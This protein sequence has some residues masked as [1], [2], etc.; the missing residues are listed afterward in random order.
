MLS[1]ITIAS[2]FGDFLHWVGAAF[3]GHGYLIMAVLIAGESAGLPLPGETSLLA[4]AVAAERGHLDIYLVILIAAGAAIVGDNIGY[5]FGRRVGRGLLERHAHLLRISERKI[6]VLEYSFAQHGA[7][8][9]FFGRWVT[10]LRST[11]GPLAG[12]SHMPWPRF[13]LFN[14]LGGLSWAATMGTLGYVFSASVS[15]IKSTFGIVGAV[16]LVLVVVLG[17]VFVRRAERRLFAA[18][19]GDDPDHPAHGHERDGD[20]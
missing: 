10:I 12:A 14:A 4:G 16:A 19:K 5:L 15:T 6:A 3:A 8:M 1:I 20:H 18:P 11:A 2:W 17:I 9:V 13:L 7:K